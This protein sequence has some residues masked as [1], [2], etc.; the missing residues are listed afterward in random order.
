MEDL[1]NFIV[2]LDTAIENKA[3][4]F[5]KKILPEMQKN[6]SIQL[7]AAQAIKSILLKK[8]LIT[9]DPYKYDN[10]MTDISIPENT[11]FSESEKAGV[12]GTR[13]STYE[14]MLDFLNN[15]YQFNTE[16]LTPKKI[17]NL[18]N[19]NKS[20][21]WSDFTSSSTNNN[22]RGLADIIQSVLTGED[23]LTAGL[24]RDSLSHLSKTNQEINKSL[25]Q[26]S[27][28]KRE[29]YKLWIRKLIFS[30]IEISQEDLTN[31]SKALK[32]IK[33]IISAS[34]KKAPF[35][36]DLIIELI[37]EDYASDSAEKHK[38]LLK[39]LEA[40]NK[41]E[42][43]ENKEV[44]Y[45][46]YLLEGLK[47][48]GNSGPHFYEA[49]EKIKY[50]NEIIYKE[51]SGTFKK[52]IA[53]MK[54]AFNIKDKEREININ[55]TDPVTQI[56][57]KQSIKYNEFINEMSKKAILFKN[58]ANPGSPVQQKIKQF[59][60]DLL[61]TNLTKYISESNELLKQ[62]TGLDEFYKTIKPELRGKIRGIKIEITTI[63]NSII[64]ANQ[65]RAEYTTS[66]EE[67]QQMERMGI[68]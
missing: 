47:I 58:I 21:L 61:L 46:P 30:K 50:N 45:R 19:L 32:D 37:K 17:S 66:M 24:L 14:V 31:P 34:E 2:Q 59:N 1:R 12:I 9:D 16:F 60:D 25:E 10:K 56:K 65:Y 27:Q 52:F 13:L 49:L 44:N 22:T 8:S 4:E 51:E 7:T 41:V 33:K 28:F 42:K 68:I 11:G 5:N 67:K 26:L 54:K 29:K 48:L 40:N 3:E 64:K 57:K 6:Y 15:Y 35:Y 38:A 53:A 23:N 43:E 63:T 62:M 36:S 18:L 39:R 20:F 55:I